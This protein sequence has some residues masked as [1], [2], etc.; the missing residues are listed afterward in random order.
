[1]TVGVMAHRLP[2]PIPPPLPR[3]PVGWVPSPVEPA[4]PE[5]SAEPPWRDDALFVLLVAIIAA[6]TYFAE[7]GPCR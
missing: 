2:Y 3:R 7:A 6:I 1:M 5:G 4:E